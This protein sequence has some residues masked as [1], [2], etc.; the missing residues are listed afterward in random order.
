MC[1]LENNLNL[2]EHNKSLKHQKKLMTQ[3][4]RGG[5]LGIYSSG[6]KTA[7]KVWSTPMETTILHPIQSLFSQLKK[8]QTFE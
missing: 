6:V 2:L 4:G 5:I 7:L 8:A 1:S 3:E